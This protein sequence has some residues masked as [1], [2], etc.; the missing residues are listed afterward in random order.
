[1][2][3]QILQ[4]SELEILESKFI[5]IQNKL[6]KSHNDQQKVNKSLTE[7]KIQVTVLQEERRKHIEQITVLKSEVKAADEKTRS[8]EKIIG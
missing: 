7:S 6:T 8:D 5:Q 2:S 3:S 4:K 1:M